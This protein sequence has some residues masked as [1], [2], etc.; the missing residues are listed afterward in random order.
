MSVIPGHE[1]QMQR[2]RSSGSALV[3]PGGQAR[4]PESLLLLKKKKI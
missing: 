2:I 3:R 4:L 1:Q